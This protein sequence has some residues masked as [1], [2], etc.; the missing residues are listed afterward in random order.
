MPGR[1]G[2]RPPGHGLVVPE[3]LVSEGD[4]VAAPLR[5]KPG[6]FFFLLVLVVSQLFRQVLRIL[7][8]NYIFAEFKGMKYFFLQILYFDFE[9]YYHQSNFFCK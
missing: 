3:A 6:V 8:L 5:K 4:V 2:S 1:A 7:I 9:T